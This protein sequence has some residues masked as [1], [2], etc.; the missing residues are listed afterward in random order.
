MASLL[1]DMIGLGLG[2]LG[3]GLLIAAGI[4]RSLQRQA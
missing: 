4:V 3:I 2:L 1:L